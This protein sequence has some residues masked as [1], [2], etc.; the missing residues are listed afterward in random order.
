MGATHKAV[1]PI[2]TAPVTTHPPKAARWKRLGLKLLLAGFLIIFSIGSFAA[3]EMMGHNFHVVS[4]GQVY[5]SAQFDPETLARL[6]QQ[7]GIKSV[8]NLRGGN[9]DAEWYYSE[10]NAAG[11]LGIKH[12]DIEIS[13]SQELSNEQMDKILGIIAEA[14]KPILIHCKNGADRT[15]LAGALYL[16][17]VEGKSAKIADRQLSLFRGHIPYLFWRDTIAMDHSFWRY[18]GAHSQPVKPFSKQELTGSSKAPL[19]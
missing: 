18:V 10:T 17:S 1:E 19:N 9:W 8:L 6:V 11:Q 7:N 13:A 4:P 12:Y 3:Y 2:C 16:Y 14:P 15:G 5:R